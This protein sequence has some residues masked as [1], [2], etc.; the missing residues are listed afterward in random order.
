[1]YKQDQITYN[2]WYAIKPNPTKPNQIYNLF[3]ATLLG[4]FPDRPIISFNYVIQYIMYKRLE[5]LS[6]I[7]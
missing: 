4:S 5:V 7:P 6:H 1:M 3:F 2:G